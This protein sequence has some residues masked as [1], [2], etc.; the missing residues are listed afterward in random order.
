MSWE[1]MISGLAKKR[2][3][4]EEME[5]EN[6]DLATENGLLKAEINKLNLKN[7]SLEESEANEKVKVK[8][9]EGRK[10]DL[11]AVI[12]QIKD[13][14]TKVEVNK[15][16]ASRLGKDKEVGTPVFHFLKRRLMNLMGRSKASQTMARPVKSML[17][18]SYS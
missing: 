18:G 4:E 14:K 8:E 9:L 6:A 1:E 10:K 13:Q 5:G 11:L 17:Q 12:S 15:G 7:R 2:K 16:E 3:R